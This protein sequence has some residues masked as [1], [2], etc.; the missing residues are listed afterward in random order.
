MGIA[1]LIVLMLAVAIA[2]LS[3]GWHDGSLAVAVDAVAIEMR[4]IL[5]AVVGSLAA[6]CL[7]IGSLIR[8]ESRVVGLLGLILSIVIGAATVLSL[9]AT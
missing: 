4:A 1:S 9:S 7:S 6:L 2:W 3:F 5:I 8:G